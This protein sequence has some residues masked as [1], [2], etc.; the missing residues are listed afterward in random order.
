MILPALA[1]A[2]ALLAPAAMTG[3]DP[4]TGEWLT[5]DGAAK[6]AIAPCS[7]APARMCGAVTWL[8][9][10]VH[11]PTRDVMNPDKALRG[12]PLVGL[13]VVRDMQS[14]GPGRWTGGKIY[15]AESGKTYAGKLKALSRNRLQV[16]GC[17]LMVCDSETWTR[18][19]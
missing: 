18:A 2:L 4:A 16:E 6:V 9:D 15:D 8:Q 12:R 3:A 7:Y 11:K 5:E 10:P 1:S 14:A 17:V 19:N 13:L